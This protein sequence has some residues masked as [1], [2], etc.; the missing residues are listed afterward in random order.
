MRHVAAA[1]ML[2]NA[3][4]PAPVRTEP[5][6]DPLPPL[7]KRWPRLRAGGDIH[8]QAEPAATRR[9]RTATSSSAAA[10]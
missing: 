3:T 8:D 6:V 10:R 9:S 7:T 2:A 5:V 4:P 1:L